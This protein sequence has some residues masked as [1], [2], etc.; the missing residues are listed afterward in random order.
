MFSLTQSTVRRALPLFPTKAMPV[1][2]NL[3]MRLTIINLVKYNPNH[4]QDGLLLPEIDSGE[5]F[6]DSWLVFAPLSGLQSL[7]LTLD[8]QHPP[9]PLP[10]KTWVS[11]IVSL[12]LPSVEIFPRLKETNLKLDINQGSG[13]PFRPA[14]F[15]S[16]IL[17]QVS[18]GWISVDVSSKPCSATRFDTDETVTIQLQRSWSTLSPP[19]PSK[20]VI[21]TK[22]LK[23]AVYHH[24][25]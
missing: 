14:D 17:R 23:A 5:N 11:V 18:S 22:P 12:V 10:L 24:V 21:P 2:R 6:A 7:T 19:T 25:Y 20:T 8:Y 15:G 4:Y 1:I 9:H 3:M 13:P 16:E